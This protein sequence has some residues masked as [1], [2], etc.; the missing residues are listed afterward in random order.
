MP[1]II[2]LQLHS[3]NG[4]TL[5]ASHAIIELTPELEKELDGRVEKLTEMLK[6]ESVR[7]IVYHA[8]IPLFLPIDE[9]IVRGEPIIQEITDERLEN[10]KRFDEML[11]I[12]LGN[13]EMRITRRGEAPAE[14]RLYM[15]EKHTGQDV[16]T[17]EFLWTGKTPFKLVNLG[18]TCSECGEPSVVVS[19]RN[20]PLCADCGR[21]EAERQTKADAPGVWPDWAYSLLKK[22]S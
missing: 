14:V 10:L 18:P 6:D 9:Q 2:V 7:A 17:S 13:C 16:F 12:R 19:D 1:K 11:E 20:K 15:Y 5:N 8:D 3:D 21:E 4:D 22:K